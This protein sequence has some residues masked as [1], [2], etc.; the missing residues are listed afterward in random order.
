MESLNWCLGPILRR[1]VLHHKASLDLSLSGHCVKSQHVVLIKVQFH[2]GQ[3]EPAL[4][5]RGSLERPGY[6]KWNSPSIYFVKCSCVYL[7]VAMKRSTTQPI[8]TANVLRVN[9]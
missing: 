1:T 4:V 9:K 6:T 2:S 5:H 3:M 8:T 7:L